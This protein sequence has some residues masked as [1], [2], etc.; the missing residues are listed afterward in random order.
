MK[1]CI[2]LLAYYMK[3]KKEQKEFHI[4]YIDIKKECC[5]EKS[6]HPLRIYK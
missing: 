6:Q 3:D 4:T 5:K 1:F 2:A